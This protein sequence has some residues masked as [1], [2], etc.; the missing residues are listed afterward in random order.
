MEKLYWQSLENLKEQKENSVLD[1]KEPIPELILSNA[2]RIAFSS[3]LKSLSKSYANRGISCINIAPG[4]INTDRLK[5]LV[6]N[7]DDFA[8]TLPL[9]RIG[10]PDEIGEFVLHFNKF[11]ES[12]KKTII[13]IILKENHGYDFRNEQICKLCPL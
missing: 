5:N 2:Y 11:V 1:K 6:E 4:P 8:S 3:V 7:L 12:I 13:S 10:R 9:K